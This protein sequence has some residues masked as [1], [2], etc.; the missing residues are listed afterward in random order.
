MTL[1]GIAAKMVVALAVVCFCVST[2][3]WVGAATPQKVRTPRPTL[4]SP[5]NGDTL[6]AGESIFIRW[7]V[8]TT[9]INV[10]F[11]E[12]E[13]FLIIDNGKS[14][15]LV[16]REIGENVR[17]IE[18]TV[19]NRPTTHATLSFGAGCDQRP[20]AFYEGLFP[21]TQHVFQILPPRDYTASVTMNSLKGTEA[22]AGDEV[23]ISWESSVEQVDFFEIQVSYNRGNHFHKI[24]KTRNQKFTWT[25]PE[26]IRGTATFRVIARKKDGTQVKSGAGA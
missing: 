10:P 8:D 14:Y 18:W 19:P 17:E 12:Q 3:D 26:D 25:V 1:R 2:Y 15:E 7:E 11:C 20:F 9:G 21:Q 24:G 23:E 22:Q 13:I 6:I 16:A 4:V 5:R